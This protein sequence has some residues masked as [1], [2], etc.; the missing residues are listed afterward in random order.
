MLFFG[1]W[2]PASLAVVVA[3]AA[4]DAGLVSSEQSLQRQTHTQPDVSQSVTHT[5]TLTIQLHVL[6]TGKLQQ[7]IIQ[8]TQLNKGSYLTAMLETYK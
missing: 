8:Q 7:N 6:V 5:T 4:G 2:L 1:A 3:A